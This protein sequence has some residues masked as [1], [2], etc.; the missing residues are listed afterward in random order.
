MR[1]ALDRRVDFDLPFENE[2]GRWECYGYQLT[3]AE[4]DECQCT[5]DWPVMDLYGD[6]S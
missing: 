1:E 2:Y 4:F 5:G 3:H 6:I